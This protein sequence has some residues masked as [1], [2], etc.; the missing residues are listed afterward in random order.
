MSFNQNKSSAAA[1]FFLVNRRRREESQNQTDSTSAAQTGSTSATQKPAA[2]SRPTTFGSAKPAAPLSGGFKIPLNINLPQPAAST[3]ATSAPLSGSFKIPLNIN[4][5]QQPS[6]PYLSKFK[7]PNNASDSF[8][9]VDIAQILAAM[10]AGI[11]TQRDFEVQFA[12]MA[13]ILA[14][15]GRIDPK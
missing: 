4:L 12:N 14:S 2:A 9:Q 5:Q 6:H 10:P 8:Y 1:P 11:Q 7:L 3:P 13:R 15:Q